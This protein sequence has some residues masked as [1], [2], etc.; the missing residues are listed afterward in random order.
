M[1]KSKVKLNTLAW[2]QEVMASAEM[3]SYLSSLGGAVAA[4]VEGGSVS[5]SSSRTVAFP[6]RRSRAIVSSS[7]SLADEAETGALLSAL[8]SSL[9]QATASNNKVKRARNKRAKGRKK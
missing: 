9:P 1:A 3:Q 5:V 2:G 4:R 7:K 8:K 6:G